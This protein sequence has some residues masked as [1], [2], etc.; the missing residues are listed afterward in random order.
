MSYTLYIRRGT[1]INTDPQRR[2]YYGA[3]A[4]SRT[5]WSPW[6]LWIK[7]YFFPTK[8]SADH[9]ASLFCREDQQ[10]KAMEVK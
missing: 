7:D 10:L 3:H 8:E 6:E 1:I 4:S 9:A 2:C 5:D